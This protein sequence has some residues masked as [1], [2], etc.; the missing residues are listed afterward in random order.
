MIISTQSASGDASAAREL[1]G[2]QVIHLAL[3]IVLE[4]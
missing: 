2:V 4:A 3:G 1:L